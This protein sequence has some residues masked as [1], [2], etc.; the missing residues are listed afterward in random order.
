MKYETKR[1]ES[2]KP[3]AKMDWLAGRLGAGDLVIADCRHVSGKPEEGRRA[4]AEDHIPGA[5]YLDLEQDLC[6]PVR[7]HGG[8][9]PLPDLGTFSL[10]MGELGI[11]NDTTVVAYDDQGGAIAARLWWMLSFL[12]HRRACVL[13]GGYSAW[14]AAGYP[15]SGDPAAPVRR[16]FLPR[17]HTG[18]MV[19]LH[20]LQDKL[21]AAGTVLVDSREP[22]RFRGEADP[23]DGRAG[24]IPGAVN[25]YWKE[26]LDGRGLFKPAEEQAARFADI[27]REDEVIVYS[28]SGVTACV[29]VLALKEAGYANVRLYVGGWSDWISYPENPVAGSGK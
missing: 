9:H 20:E 13:E 3:I 4:Y 25:R 8:R 14:K 15:V 23:V 2:M 12:G 6:G 10:L 26:A 16:R 29:N 24:T 21:G 5:V 18:M 19:P 1:V 11:G 28:G 27:G 7:E 17:V 22:A